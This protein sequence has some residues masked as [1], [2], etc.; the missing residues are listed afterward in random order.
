MAFLTRLYARG[1]NKMK[2]L[3]LMRHGKAEPYA[4]TDAQRALTAAGQEKVRRTTHLLSQSGFTPQIL[5]TSP[6]L[7]AQQSAE[8][9]GKILKLIPQT[10]P[11]LDGRLTTQG[12]LDFALE[13]LQY[14]DRVMLVGHNPNLSLT[15][16]FLCGEYFSFDAGD[17]AVF[18]LTDP[19]NP[20][21][22]S[23][24]IK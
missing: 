22:F 1:T 4:E 7:R 9:A 14:T 3:I 19:E 5:L 10:V 20:R 23:L 8:E 13:Q 12:L 21:L 18:D 6:L 2:I 17:A 24:E 15:A 11:Q 16:S